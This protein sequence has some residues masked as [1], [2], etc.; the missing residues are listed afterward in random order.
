MVRY[1][2]WTFRVGVCDK[3]YGTDTADIT[4]HFSGE[5]PN[6][7]PVADAGGPYMIS[8]GSPLTLD[9][10]GSSDPDGDLL[11]YA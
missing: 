1:A 4:V 9:A 3:F 8:E 7:L 6:Q 5:A 2:K 10:S 11:T